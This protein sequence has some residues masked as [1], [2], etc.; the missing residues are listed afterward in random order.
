MPTAIDSDA[1]IR[2]SVIEEIEYDPVVTAHDI[3]VTVHDRTVTLTG[4]A[5]AYG[6]RQAAERAAWRVFG[7]TEVTDNFAI[8][9]V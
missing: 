2:E 4:V 9:P 5:D 3:D 6:T 1:Q 8:Q 7:V